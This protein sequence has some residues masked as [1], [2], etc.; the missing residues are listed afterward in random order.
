MSKEII[1]KRKKMSLDE[2]SE[3]FEKMCEER[4]SEMKRVLIKNGVLI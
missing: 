1:V 4:S 3:L 2:F